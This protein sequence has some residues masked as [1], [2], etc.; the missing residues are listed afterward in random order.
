MGKYYQSD[1]EIA[2][3]YKE[4]VHEKYEPYE[5][6][7]QNMKNS[8]RKVPIIFFLISRPLY[9]FS[10]LRV[11]FMDKLLRRSEVLQG[12]WSDLSKKKRSRTAFWITLWWFGYLLVAIVFK[13]LNALTLSINSFT[14]LGF[15]HIPNQWNSPICCDY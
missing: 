10:T 5:S 1:E 7:Y 8:K 14:T 6:F 15:G 13:A 12:K 11:K 9:W 2:T 4:S 3:L